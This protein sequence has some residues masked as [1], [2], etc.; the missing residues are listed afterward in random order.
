VQ[1]PAYNEDLLA[2]R[3]GESRVVTLPIFV[4]TRCISVDGPY[5]HFGCPI[6]AASLALWSPTSNPGVNKITMTTNAC[7]D[8][9]CPCPARLWAGHRDS[10]KCVLGRPGRTACHEP[11]DTTPLFLIFIS[12]L[13]VG[14]IYEFRKQEQKNRE[15]NRAVEERI[16]RECLVE[17]GRILSISKPS[18]R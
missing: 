8:R 11:G 16:Q 5:T 18:L 13:T 6:D 1:Q 3:A 15:L 2:Q 12:I 9:C 17:K 14:V 10:A 7:P 4:V